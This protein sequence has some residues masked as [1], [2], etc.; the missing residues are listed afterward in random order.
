MINNTIPSLAFGCEQLGGY[1]WG[2]VE[3]KEIAKSIDRSWEKGVRFYDTAPVY[4]LGLSEERLSDILKD[5]RKDSLIATKCG[6]KWIKPRN[7]RAKILVDNSNESITESVLES[8]KRLRL[9]IIPIVFIH[10]KDP[11]IPLK[12]SLD[13]LFELKERG[14][15]QYTGLSNHSPND[16]EEAAKEYNID[17]AQFEFNYLNRINLPSLDVCK[18]NDIKLVSSS[19]LA[20]GMLTEGFLDSNSYGLDDRRSRLEEFKDLKKDGN[21]KIIEELSFLAK[22]NKKPM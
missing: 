22:K 13:S 6:L 17:Y 12:E 9:D 10:R 8:L 20:R 2:N 5:K 1:D 4:G 15:I 3:I 18:K 11:K 21:I 7:K 14:L 16:I 19:S